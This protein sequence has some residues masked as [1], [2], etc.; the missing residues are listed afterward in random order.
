MTRNQRVTR[1]EYEAWLARY[2]RHLRGSAA[3]RRLYIR[4]RVRL[5]LAALAFGACIVLVVAVVL[6][7]L[8]GLTLGAIALGDW[9]L[10]L[11]H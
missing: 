4:G 9:L 10:Y 7:V 5:F 11:L 1:A 6:G 8:Y 2:E 3:L